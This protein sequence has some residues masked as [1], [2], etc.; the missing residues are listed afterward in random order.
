MRNL[1]LRLFYKEN[2]CINLCIVDLSCLSL[3]K[4]IVNLNGGGFLV[5]N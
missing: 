2:I 5:V 4:I 1:L 3:E